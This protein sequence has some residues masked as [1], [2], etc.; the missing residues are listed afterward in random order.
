MGVASIAAVQCCKDSDRV[1]RGTPLVPAVRIDQ[2]N[3]GKIEVGVVSLVACS[4]GS[5]VT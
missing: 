3:G 5:C 4:L 1:D 2:E